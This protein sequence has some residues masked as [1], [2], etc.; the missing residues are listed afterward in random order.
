MKA[1]GQSSITV[2]LVTKAVGGP[3]ER[4]AKGSVWGC[5]RSTI[6]HPSL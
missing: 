3:W 6:V 1:S 5:L 2:K 4:Q